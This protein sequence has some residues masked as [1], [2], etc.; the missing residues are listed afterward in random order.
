MVIKECSD[1]KRSPKVYYKGEHVI[2]IICRNDQCDY[3]LHR[4]H[5]TP[6]S[7]QLEDL[8]N[9]LQR[10]KE[11][12][13]KQKLK[14]LLIVVSVLLG[15]MIAGFIAHMWWILSQIRIGL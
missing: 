9:Y 10:E 6:E 1:C 12:M 14:K 2:A 3:S 13:R 8:W 7:F 11:Y 5:R 4:H 15:I